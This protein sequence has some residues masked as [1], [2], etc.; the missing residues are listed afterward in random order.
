MLFIKIFAEPDTFEALILSAFLLYSPS[1]CDKSTSIARAIFFCK[2]TLPKLNASVE[3]SFCKFKSPPFAINLAA[4][5]I[6]ALVIKLATASLSTLIVFSL[7]V[8][9]NVTS[10]LMNV[11]PPVPSISFEIV[12]FNRFKVP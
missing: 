7:I 10:P 3:L 8:L 9:A 2:S 5:L 11:V 12:P 1:S 4:S 6:S